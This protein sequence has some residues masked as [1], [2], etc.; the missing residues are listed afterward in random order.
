MTGKRQQLVMV[1]HE[2]AQGQMTAV[3]AATVLGVSEQQVWRLLAAY[4]RAGFSPYKRALERFP[5]PRLSGILP[6]TSAPQVPLLGTDAFP[7]ES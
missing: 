6:K 2:V 3:V 5:D 1:L 7:P 4:R